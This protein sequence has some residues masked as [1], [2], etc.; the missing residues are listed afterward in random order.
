MIV[1]KNISKIYFEGSKKE[2][3]ALKNI[4]FEIKKGSFV[5]FKGVSG[6]GKSTLINQTLFPILF[7]KL[8]KG[9]LYPLEYSEISGIENLDKV[10]DIDQSP[11]GK[12][13]RSNPATYT[14]IFDDILI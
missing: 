12:T 9:K 6:S 3:Y 4:N 7:N 8:N 2:F 1:A 13:P 10:V 5:I 11:I 14:K